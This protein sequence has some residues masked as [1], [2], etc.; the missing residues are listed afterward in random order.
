MRHDRRM[1]SV[2]DGPGRHSKHRR[3]TAIGWLAGVVCVGAWLPAASEA[4]TSQEPAR[5]ESPGILSRSLALPS[6]QLLDGAQQ[7]EDQ[8]Y[9]LNS[10]P[11]VRS[12]RIASRTE[13]EHLSRAEI[14]SLMRRALPDV[15]QTGEDSL[16]SLPA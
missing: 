6:V 14:S 2:V 5:P 4:A 15:V 1:M 7:I 10:D 11:A 12:A 9:V 13:F 8:R 16:P 3:R